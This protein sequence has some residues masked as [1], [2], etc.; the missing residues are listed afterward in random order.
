MHDGREELHEQ[1]CWR[2]LA[3]VERSACGRR[4]ARVGAATVF[5]VQMTVRSFL[6]VA[7]E[8]TVDTGKGGEPYDALYTLCVGDGAVAEEVVDVEASEVDHGVGV[9]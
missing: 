3:D 7:P 2:T 4:H 5:A 1:R 6:C 8:A 9:E